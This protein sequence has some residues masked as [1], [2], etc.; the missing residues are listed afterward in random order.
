MIKALPVKRYLALSGGV[1]GAKLALGLS[2]ILAPEQLTIVANT[3]DDFEHLGLSISP[4]LDTVMYT[5][6]EINNKE[7]GW[8]LAGESWDTMDALA[9]LGG[10][11]W[12]RLGDRDLATHLQRSTLLASGVNLSGVT[13]SLCQQLGIIHPI[14]PM[15]DDPVRTCVRT[16]KGDLAFQ[17]YFVR[18]QCTPEVEGFYFD[19]IESAKPQP[20]MMDLLAGD[21]LAAIIICPSNP[22][23]SVDPIL[24]LANVKDAMRNNSAPVIAISPIVA[25]MAIKGPAAKMMSELGIPATAA[26]VAR[27]YGNLIDGFVLDESDYGLKS[28]IEQCGIH[29]HCTNT[30]M[31]TLDDRIDLAK[32]VLS[33]IDSID[34]KTNKKKKENL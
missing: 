22:F 27:F 21:E 4:D 8:G 9:R 33:F 2:K 31:K 13:Q 5:L 24:G 23:V 25:G 19:G 16:D 3:G 6:A 26:E 29:V 18:E 28:E 11:T 15:S 14:I 1:G 10:E 30:I 7:L 34:D 32:D 20:Q 17:Q 12:F